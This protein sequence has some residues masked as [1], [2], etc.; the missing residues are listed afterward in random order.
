MIAVEDGGER[1]DGAGGWLY[2]ISSNSPGRGEGG[3][4]PRILE[5]THSGDWLQ[6][7]GNHLR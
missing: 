3:D 5:D 4:Q 1:E 6:S 2:I 7:L